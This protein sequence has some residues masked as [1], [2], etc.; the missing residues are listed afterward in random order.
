MNW[1]VRVVSALTRLSSRSHLLATVSG[2][3]PRL[4]LFAALAA[5]LHIPTVWLG[6]AAVAL[7]GMGL[8][9]APR[10]IAWR[11]IVVR[12]RTTSSPSYTAVAEVPCCS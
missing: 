2:R 12:H 10:R 7:L 4:W 5:P 1:L 9:A 8:V 6:F 3:F 11:R